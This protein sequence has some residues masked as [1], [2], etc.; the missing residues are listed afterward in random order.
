MCAPRPGR[1]GSR[2][3][4]CPHPPGQSA[5]TQGAASAV[6]PWDT[7]DGDDVVEVLNDVLESARDGEYGFQSCA[8][9]ADSAELKSI[10]L[11]HSQQCAAAAQELE[12]EIRRFEASPLRRHH[13][14]GGAPGLGV[15]E[16]C[17]VIARRQG[18]SGGVRAWWKTLRWPATAR[19]W[20]AALPA[21]ARALLERQAQ[22]AKRKPRRSACAAR[23]LRPAI[24][25][26]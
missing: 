23:Q 13:R 25:G 26:A 22:G 2:F 20:N 11:R 1:P 18:R 8:D 21:D 12:R 24:S 14:R 6:E 5:G 7:S 16:G 10:F 19:P 17:A 15:G 3:H 4:P 9:H